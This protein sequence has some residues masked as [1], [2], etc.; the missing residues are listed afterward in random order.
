MSAALYTLRLLKKMTVEPARKKRRVS[1]GEEDGNVPGFAKFDLEQDYAR[2][3][4]KK[5]KKD[6]A[7]DKL[8]VKTTD[9]WAEN[10][11]LRQKDE[12]DADSFLASDDDAEGD[13]GVADLESKPALPPKPEL[14][15][16]EQVRQAK[17][18]LAKVAGAISEDAEEN[19]AQLSSLSQLAHSENPT[20]QKLALGTQLAVFKDIIPGYRIRPLSKDDM[21]GKVSK[22]VKKLRAFEQTLLSSYREY[23]HHLAALAKPSPSRDAKIASVALS[24][25]CA[26]LTAHSHFNNRN[27]LIAL[28][29]RQLS[30]RNLTA[31]ATK[32]LEALE[33]L[34]RDDAEGH[35]SL[36]AITQLSKMLKSKSYQVH[37]S[38]LNTFLH[39]RLLDEFAH[40]ASPT[41][42]SNTTDSALTA[43]KKQGE[44]KQPREFRT[45][46]ER[47]LLRE[48]KAVEKEFRVADAAVG[49][50]TRDK[51]QAETLKLVF[52]AYFRILKERDKARHLMSAVLEGLAKYAHLINREFFGDVL[53]VLRELIVEGEVE[54]EI[55]EEDEGLSEVVGNEGLSDIRK[56]SRR[57]MLLCIVTAFELLRGQQGAAR[58]MQLDLEFFVGRLYAGLGAWAMDAEVEGDT[59]AVSAKAGGEARTTPT[60]LL[61][62]RAL[63]SILVPRDAP[64]SRVAAFV[65]QLL[66]LSLHLPAKSA[67]AVLA[68]LG[69]VVKV[70]GRK[71]GGLWRTEE[72]RGDGVWDPLAGSGSMEGVWASTVWEGEVLRSHWDQ[73]VREGVREVERG[74]REARG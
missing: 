6:K 52:V 13:S 21:H 7:S 23:V 65:K 50:E 53:E 54:A 24:C 41:T 44:K 33:H 29:V 4:A 49:Y 39:L 63:P 15:P 36:E 14:P 56:R 61:L 12:E 17:E 67:Q 71:I 69:Q 73:K 38:V 32:C 48:R 74:V 30:S 47:K 2:R 45:K 27:D 31:N 5:S 16:H 25:A 35:A 58:E 8:L 42:I 10:E 55:D 62:L 64:P 57:Q 20:V 9:G 43:G 68:L 3:A 26:L 51:N 59:F 70:H 46:R 19:I 18:E 37:Q 60:I 11:R 40:K 1:P 66:T 22:D 72:K 28:V 34:F